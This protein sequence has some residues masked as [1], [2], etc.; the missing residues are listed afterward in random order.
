M[1]LTC[2]CR[3]PA[4]AR[5]SCLDT[6]IFWLV[7]HAVTHDDILSPLI[8][9][10]SFRLR[11]TGASSNH[12]CMLSLVSRS[13]Q[14]LTR[15]PPAQQHS[16]ADHAQS[17]KAQHARVQQLPF[18]SVGALLTRIFGEEKPD[19][20]ELPDRGSFRVHQ[21]QGD[22]RCMFRAMVCT[23]CCCCCCCW[24]WL[25]HASWHYCAPS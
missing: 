14:T 5:S 1:R 21:I 23:Y 9:A 16:D 8:N 17:S 7:L 13:N 19:P 24:H 2:R 20:W 11:D 12:P 25:D 3:D 10:G 4:F 18:A 15:R 6:S 22:G